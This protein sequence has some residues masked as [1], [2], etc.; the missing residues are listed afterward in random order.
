MHEQ[1]EFESV[2]YNTIYVGVETN[3]LAID[4]RIDDLRAFY[5]EKQPLSNKYIKFGNRVFI[6]PSSFKDFTATLYLGKII[7]EKNKKG[8]LAPK[9]IPSNLTDSS[10]EGLNIFWLNEINKN[11]PLR[12]KPT[13]QTPKTSFGNFPILPRPSVDN[14]FYEYQKYQDENH[15]Y[16]KIH[17][18][19]HKDNIIL[20]KEQII[21]YFT[22][23]HN[24][25][26]EFIANYIESINKNNG[27]NA[28]Y[29]HNNLF[30]NLA[31]KGILPE[32]M[33]KRYIDTCEI[34][35]NNTIDL[36]V[37]D[38]LSKTNQPN[39]KI[40]LYDELFFWYFVLSLKNFIV[41]FSAS[42]CDE[43]NLLFNAGAYKQYVHFIQN[44]IIFNT[45][46]HNGYEVSKTFFGNNGGI[47]RL[48]DKDKS[49]K[50]QF[51]SPNQP[52]S[53][54]DEYEIYDMTETQIDQASKITPSPLGK[55]YFE[56]SDNKSVYI[57]FFPRIYPSITNPPKGWNKEMMQKLDLRLE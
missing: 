5:Y 36:I 28:Y 3:I 40:L 41:S 27:I 33:I 55:Y 1:I 42:F 21:S 10:F 19:R 47:T 2:K 26:T 30:E 14:D 35:R 29:L 9:F 48:I 25:N 16:L 43:N 13:I 54:M 37:L 57:E 17:Y 45:I 49:I 20:T 7:F 56:L 38:F 39:H 23:L 34:I 46:R 11:A 12:P 22:E 44:R 52:I 31:Q 51:T 4:D 32:S 24:K 18:F 53:Q 8:I 15:K 6:S 50:L